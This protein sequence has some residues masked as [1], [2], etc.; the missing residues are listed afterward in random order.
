M[1][2]QE[3]NNTLL[4]IGLG[5]MGRA[6]LT[7]LLSSNKKASSNQKALAREITVIDPAFADSH[8][9]GSVFISKKANPEIT[10]QTHSDLRECTG[11]FDT[12]ILT[13]KPQ[14]AT[15][16]I[17]LLSRHIHAG[18]TLISAMAGIT[19]ARI[20]ELL[21]ASGVNIIRAMP[22]IAMQYDNGITTLYIPT[23]SSLQAAD[24]AR[25]I[26]ASGGTILEV[27]Q[28]HL[29]DAAT[30]ISGSG[31][32]F[33]FHLLEGVYHEVL[34]LGFNAEQAKQLI[35][36]TLKGTALLY[37]HAEVS[38]AELEAQVTSPQ[39]TTAAGVEVLKSGEAQ[40]V[41]RSCLRR[42]MERSIELGKEL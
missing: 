42:A 31:P 18:T 19:C 36:E 4:V 41:I 20:Y 23:G 21:A 32:G 8:S 11:S 37:E 17:P 27:T 9:A 13:I 38:L 15:A 5:N 33:F 39:G 16:V 34:A 26:F 12:I 29:V 30:A 24:T 35:H 14:L 22:N 3:N 10:I 25:S 6:L 1:N 28:E 40:S 2:K 7:P